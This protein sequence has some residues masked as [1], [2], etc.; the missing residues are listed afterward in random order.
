NLSA[1]HDF[2]TLKALLTLRGSL[3]KPRLTLGSTPDMPQTEI[4]SWILFQ[5]PFSEISPMEGITL[6][7]TILT[8]KGSATPFSVFNSFKRHLGIDQIDISKTDTAADPAYAF[9]VGKYLSKNLFVRLS[10]DVANAANRVAI[11]ANLNKNLSVQ[12]EVGDDQQGQMSL[13][14]KHDY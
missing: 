12:A 3:E 10:K 14:W 11:Q 1:V 2:N 6:A 13:V 4:L 9:H 5:K 8:L 7:D